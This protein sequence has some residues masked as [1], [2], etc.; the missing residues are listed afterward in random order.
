MAYVY[1]STMA[2]AHIRLWTLYRGDAKLVP[3]WGSSDPG[4]WSEYKDVGDDTAGQEIEYCF[5]Q[6]KQFPPT[7]H[8]GQSAY[9]Y[10]TSS[11]VNISSQASI[12]GYR[13]SLA[14]SLGYQASLAPILG[15]RVSLAPI[16]GYQASV[17]PTLGYPTTSSGHP[18]SSCV[19]SDRG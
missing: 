15:Y 12:S 2:G 10:G 18:S 1:V 16:L 8:A 7:P 11:T 3:F 9:T 5:R 4:K 13:V 6:M 19:R 14:P 17:A